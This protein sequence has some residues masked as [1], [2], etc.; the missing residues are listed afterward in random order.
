MSFSTF[1]L[2]TIE[3]LGPS[4]AYGSNIANALGDIMEV[5]SHAQV[6]V[7]LARLVLAKLVR[8][9]SVNQERVRG[10]GR[11][12]VHYEVTQTG[13]V[14][15]RNVLEILRRMEEFFA[16]RASERHAEQNHSVT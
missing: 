11:P 5:R 16:E 14:Q 6:Y 2:L 7:A 9:T 10:R 3:E 1:L 13:K 4:D 12:R 8:T 15:N